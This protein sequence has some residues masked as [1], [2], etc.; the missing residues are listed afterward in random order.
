MG[1]DSSTARPGQVYIFFPLFQSPLHRGRL[2]N[3]VRR[4]V[5]QKIF[6]LSVPSS[7][8]KTLQ[9]P[10]KAS[11]FSLDQL[12]VPSSSGKSLQ[13]FFTALAPGG[14]LTFSPHFSMEDT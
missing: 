11:M 8:G 1:V 12:S 3:E 4:D 13:L 6:C 7:S 5:P 2:F 10:E 14:L 9:R